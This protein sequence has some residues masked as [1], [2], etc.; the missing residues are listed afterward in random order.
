MKKFLFGLLAVSLFFSCGKDKDEFDKESFEE[1][2]SQEIAS[3]TL[4]EAGF[5]ITVTEALTRGEDSEYYTDGKLE[6]IKDGELLA[7][8]D[9]AVGD[10]KYAGAYLNG[11]EKDIDL[12]KESDGKDSDYKKVVIEPIVKTEDCDYIVSGIL[13][14]Y[15]GGVWTATVDFGDGTCDD[16][17]TKETADGTFEFTISDWF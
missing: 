3:M 8:V 2:I 6:Y 15:K 9:F 12:S 11:E 16:I 14:Y 7:T 5:N 4:P 13:K 1:E 10:D 17:A